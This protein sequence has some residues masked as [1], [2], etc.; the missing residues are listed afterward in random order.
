[1]VPD[2]VAVPLPLSTKLTPTGGLLVMESA[3][4]GY[5]VVTTE[6]LKAAP[7]VS[8]TVAP[9]VK[10]GAWSTVRMNA[11]LVLPAELVAVRVTG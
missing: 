7:A 8:V 3:G 5:P 11:W 2:S 6:K 4:A 9:L 1:M 10:L